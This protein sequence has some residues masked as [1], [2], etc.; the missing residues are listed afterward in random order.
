MTKLTE[1]QRAF[2]AG[3]RHG[4]HLARK[5]ARHDAEDLMDELRERDDFA[6]YNNI[7]T[8]DLEEPQE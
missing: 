8:F 7:V 2:L 5:Q 1:T 3:V 6:P 4:R